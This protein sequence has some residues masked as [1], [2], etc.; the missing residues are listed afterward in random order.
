MFN[1][2][3]F[4][5]RLSILQDRLSTTMAKHAVINDVT[6]DDVIKFQKQFLGDVYIQG[7]A[8]GNLTE[9]RMFCLKEFKWLNLN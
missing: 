6:L 9:G 3:L 2:L 4:Q 1:F 8:Q 5:V 7:L